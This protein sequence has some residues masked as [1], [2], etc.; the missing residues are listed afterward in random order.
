MRMQKKAERKEV[1]I[2]AGF[3]S[4]TEQSLIVWDGPLS[5]SLP[6]FPP[7]FLSS[8]NYITSSW[9]RI[10]SRDKLWEHMRIRR[11]RDEPKLF[12][13]RC[14]SSSRLAA[15][16][17]G[18]ELGLC[19]ALLM[20]WGQGHVFLLRWTS[21]L[22]FST[23]GVSA[24]GFLWETEKEREAESTSCFEISRAMCG[25]IVQVSIWGNA[26]PHIW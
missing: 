14:M 26:A 17:L 6:G 16:A 23:P 13:Q 21:F 18:A 1:C 9:W 7:H 11:D 10:K 24:F 12:R 5:V 3:C 25:E 4:S 20:S 8:L 19:R 2:L 22:L 15:L